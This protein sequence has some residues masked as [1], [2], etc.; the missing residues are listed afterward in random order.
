MKVMTVRECL[1]RAR[2][3]YRI[4][5]YNLAEKMLLKAIERN[6]RM[7]LVYNFLGSVYDKLGKYEQAIQQIKKAIELKQDF[8]EAYNNL[9][10]PL[11]R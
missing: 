9:G 6:P 2:K 11:C 3:A 5:D 1:T 10:G 4:G 7:S 8:T